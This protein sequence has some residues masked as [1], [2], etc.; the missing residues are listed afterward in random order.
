MHKVHPATGHLQI[1]EKAKSE[2]RTCTDSTYRKWDGR[3][4]FML[5]QPLFNTKK[6]VTGS[7]FEIKS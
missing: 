6:L 4:R 5:Y 1:N 2:L 3:K 7:I